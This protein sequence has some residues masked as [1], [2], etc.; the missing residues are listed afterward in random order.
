VGVARKPPRYLEPGDAIEARIAE[1][2]V[3]ETTI[4]A[5]RSDTPLM[6]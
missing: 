1:L 6:A 4:T 3:L 5:P 2:G